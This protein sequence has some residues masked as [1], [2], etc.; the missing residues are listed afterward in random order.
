VI[1]FVKI[2]KFLFRLGENIPAVDILFLT[3]LVQ[4]WARKILNSIFLLQTTGADLRPVTSKP[5][6]TPDSY[7]GN[8]MW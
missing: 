2:L 8:F 4:T 6:N 7:F 1:V 5:T 3:A